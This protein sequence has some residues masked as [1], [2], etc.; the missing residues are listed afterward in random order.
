MSEHHLGHATQALR[1]WFRSNVDALNPDDPAA[2]ASPP[3]PP[4]SGE[5]QCGLTIADAL[6]LQPQDNAAMN[7][8]PHQSPTNTKTSSPSG[9]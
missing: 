5:T 3:G 6:A 9:L 7:P 2:R 8:T 1:E 4:D